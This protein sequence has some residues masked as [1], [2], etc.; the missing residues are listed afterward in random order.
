MRWRV[1]LSCLLA[2]GPAWGQ[3]PGDR[4]AAQVLFEEGVRL[5]ESGRVAEACAK[6]DESLRLDPTAGTR[7][8]LADCHE[9]VG[10]LASAWTLFLEVAAEMEQRGDSERAAAA[11][12]RAA[13]V[14]PR[15]ARLSIAPAEPVDGMVIERDGVAVGEAQWGTAVP[16]DLG[17]HQVSAR[18]PGKQP[19]STTVE[20]RQE[21]KAVRLDVPALLDAPAPMPGTVPLAPGVGPPAGD[22]GG[23]SAPAV[24]GIVIASVGVVGLAVGTAFG[25]IAIGK[26]SDAEALCPAYPDS[27]PTQEGIDANDEAKTAGTVATV[28]L[29]AGGVLLVGG[30]VLWIAAPSGDSNVAVQLA[31]NGAAVRLR[32]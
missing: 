11:N 14:E 4:A 10:K 15:L 23:M 30:V 13:H 29:V 7:F 26:K 28:G 19:W 31:P 3:Q 18:A 2:A 9:R 24:A 16:V 32:F 6:L 25:V 12:R 5:R 17:S 1:V 20:V 22:G 8:N 27:C 21:G